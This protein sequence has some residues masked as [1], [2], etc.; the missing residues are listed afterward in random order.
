[1][2]NGEFE[3]GLDAIKAPSSYR[4]WEEA[5][6]KLPKWRRDKLLVALETLEDWSEFNNSFGWTRL[7]ALK[8]ILELAPD[9]ELEESKARIKADIKKRC[10]A[11]DSGCDSET[12]TFF[13]V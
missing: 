9:T 2:S 6:S 12:D 3:K 10:A 13:S 4:E 1:M 7:F 5:I 8:V 11:M